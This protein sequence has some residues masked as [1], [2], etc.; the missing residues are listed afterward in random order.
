MAGAAMLIGWDP[1]VTGIQ[2]P[3]YRPRWQVMAGLVWLGLD[4]IGFECYA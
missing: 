3:S 4:W 1:A 2:T